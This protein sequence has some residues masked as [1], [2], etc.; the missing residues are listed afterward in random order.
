M[1][2]TSPLSGVFPDPVQPHFPKARVIK[3]SVSLRIFFQ[4]ASCDV[5]CLIIILMAVF[6]PTN[7][8]GLSIP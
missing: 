5:S 6:L 8:C 4:A 1:F 2:S 3:V 7:S